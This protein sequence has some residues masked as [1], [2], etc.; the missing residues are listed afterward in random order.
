MIKSLMKIGIKGPY[1]NTITTI[2]DK[3]ITSI[4]LSG[5]KL[6]AFSPKSGSRQVCP[7]LY[8]LFNIVLATFARAIG[9]EK[10]KKRGR[11]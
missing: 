4:I 5:G 1:L 9:Q 7:L 2:F 10:Q 3:L 11:I 6:Q 8:L